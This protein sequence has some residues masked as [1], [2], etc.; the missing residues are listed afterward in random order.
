M[1]LPI[2]QSAP[3]H[4]CQ[5]VHACAVVRLPPAPQF[6]DAGSEDVVILCHGYAATKVGGGVGRRRR[7]VGGMRCP[8]R[9]SAWGCWRRWLAVWLRQR[10]IPPHPLYPRANARPP[11]TTATTTTSVLPAS[12]LPA[13]VLPASVLRYLH[14]GLLECPALPHWQDGFHL[15]AIAEALAQHGRSSLR[16]D[17]A[18]NGESEVRPGSRHSAACLPLSE[19]LVS[20]TLFN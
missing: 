2:A 16:F 5:H 8:D 19:C 10:L 12:V 13:N 14:P 17:F 3:V 1:A 18:G 7:Q 20:F 9:D 6:V 4:A 11:P 15:P